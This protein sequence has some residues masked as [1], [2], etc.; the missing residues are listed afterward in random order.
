MLYLQYFETRTSRRLVEILGRGI[1]IQCGNALLELQISCNQYP[2]VLFSSPLQ[3]STDLTSSTLQKYRV[4]NRIVE[5]GHTN[6]FIYSLFIKNGEV[7]EERGLRLK[8]V[9]SICLDL[10][11][12]FKVLMITTLCSTWFFSYSF[13][14]RQEW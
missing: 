5:W 7:R 8:Y 9:R 12:A 14:V 10:F 11:C 3:P 6:K 13:I 1:A 2:Y 4:D